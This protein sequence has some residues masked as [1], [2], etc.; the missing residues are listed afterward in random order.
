[1]TPATPA[2][3][4]S[5]KVVPHATCVEC[6][7]LC[8]DITLTVESSRIVSAKNACSMGESWF[9]QSFANQAAQSCRVRGKPVDLDTAVTEAARLLH[10]AAFPLVYGLAETTCEAQR[11]AVALADSIGACLDTATSIHHGPSGV[12]FPDI[13]EVTCSLGEVKNRADLV[14][15]W[16]V[17]PIAS[18]PRHGERYSL[19][20]SGLFTPEGRKNRYAVHVDSRPSSAPE[21]FDCNLII[22]NGKDFE[23]LWALRALVKGIPIAKGFEEQTGIALADL[24]NLAQR[25]KSCHFGVLFIGMG[26]SRSAGRH[27]NNEAALGLV[28]DLNDHTRFFAKTMKVKG[29]G[30]GADNV[31]L[32]QTGYPFAVHL[33]Q[34]FPRYNPGEFSA[35]ESLERCEPDAA[36]I[37]GADPSKEFSSK[38]VARL[39]SIPTIALDFRDNETMR[40]ATVSIP[41]AAYGLQ[42]GGTVYRMD[43]VSLPLRPA[44]VSVHPSAAE[45]LGKIE[46]AV[47]RL[48]A[49]QALASAPSLAL[50]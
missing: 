46:R 45:V 50:T 12:S 39:Q 21:Q 34:G 38:A 16:G 6:G 44:L 36:L 31:L 10:E 9:L 47:H 1:M 49:E 23:A 29:N 15:F 22:P 18:H 27:M 28:T 7:C 40:Q 17:D 37:V 4:H 43:D 24:T 14:I 11:K 25:M 3:K 33:G 48:Q 32:W 2:S 26:L 20:A 13:G 19:E 5:V 35:V 30:T 8:D 42:T 41:T